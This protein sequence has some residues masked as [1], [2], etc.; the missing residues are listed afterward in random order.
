MMSKKT[1]R[2]DFVKQG[3]TAAGVAATFGTAP[4]YIK[5]SVFGANDKMQMGFIGVGGRGRSLLRD[6][7]AAAQTHP[8]NIIAV[9]DTYKK[10][11]TQASEMV[12]KSMGSAPGLQTLDYRE[13]I[14]AIAIGA[15]Q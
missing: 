9:C 4:M 15:C 11:L 14:A 2:R 1:S 3:V 10:R 7:S 13:I 12:T 6:F 8:L 5:A